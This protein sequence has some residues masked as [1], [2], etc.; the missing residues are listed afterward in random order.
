[1]DGS[2][3]IG[4]PRAFAAR[5]H[6]GDR[7]R[8]RRADR[9]PISRSRHEADV[10]DACAARRRRLRRV[11]RARARD[12]RAVFLETVAAKIEALG[13]ESRSSA[14][15]PRPACPRR[16]WRASAAAPP[17]SSA[18]SPACCAKAI[19]RAITFSTRRFA[20]S[21]AAA[22][23][24][25]APAPD[26]ARFGRGVRRLELP[27]RF[28]GRRRRHRLGLRGRLPRRGDARIPRIPAP[29][30]MVAAMR[31]AH[32]VAACGLPSRRLLAAPEA[33]P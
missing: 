28:L 32:A 14:P 17:A 22:A 7:R 25:P 11:P 24:R 8:R 15:W 6:Q 18:S 2:F 3:P 26:P 31:S 5:D 27:A 21:P 13:A 10:A 16:G 20:R 30:Q 19:G 9:H 29:R 23:R 4:R 1:M 33:R 12:A